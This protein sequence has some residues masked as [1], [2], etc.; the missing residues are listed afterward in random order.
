MATLLNKARDVLGNKD[1][2]HTESNNT[3]TVKTGPVHNHEA[4][5]KVD[6]RVHETKTRYV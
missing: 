4:L 3:E 6:P 2:S 5:N 1:T